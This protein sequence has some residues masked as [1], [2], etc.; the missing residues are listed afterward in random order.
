MV[1]A[2]HY[3]GSTKTGFLF[4]DQGY[5]GVSFFFLLSGFILAHVYGAAG[6]KESD[7]C[8]RYAVARLARIYPDYA[9]ALLISFPIVL[10]RMMKTGVTGNDVVALVT[11]PLALQS[12][13]WGSACVINCP[14]WTISDEFFFYACFPFLLAPVLGRP[15]LWGLLAAVLAVT[16]T[17][18]AVVLA[19]NING[20][21]LEQLGAFGTRFPPFRLAEFIAGMALNGWWRRRWEPVAMPIL[22]TWIVAAVAVLSMVAELVP[23]PVLTDGAAAVLWVPVI[24][25]AAQART[26]PLC[27]RPCVFLGNLSYAF[28]LLIGP[29]GVWVGAADKYVLRGVLGTH[30]WLLAMVGVTVTLVCAAIL[31][32]FFEQPMR[33]RILAFAV[34]KSADKT[35]EALRA[36]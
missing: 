9:L 33:R 18:A 31:Y 7:A 1:M 12:W 36:A 21:D 17:A 22:L 19:A 26:G 16:S 20:P 24:L 13:Y 23:Q 28:Y 4:I 29:A 27:W 30:G 25:V 8:R 6:L 5:L 3:L 32:L 35:P 34:T 14:G 15:L 10:W 2:F 11:A